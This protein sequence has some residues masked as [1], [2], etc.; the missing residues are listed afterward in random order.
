MKKLMMI[1]AMMLMG[2]GAFAQN[3]VGQVTL[4]PMAGVNLATLTGL[5][6]NK[7][8]VGLVAGVEAE[9]GVAE[10]FGVSLGALYSMQ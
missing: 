3:E 2:M 5:E 7:M 4:K 1:A 10:N 6:E 8:R 9:Y